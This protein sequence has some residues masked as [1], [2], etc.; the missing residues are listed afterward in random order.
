MFLTL[1]NTKVTALL[2]HW[3]SQRLAPE[4]LHWLQEKQALIAGGA[5]LR[6]FFTAFS[7]VPRYAGKQA[8]ALT[9][10]EL[11][12]AAALRP[13]WDPSHWR[14]DQVG[15]TFL[16]LALPAEPF[17]A[18]QRSLD[19]LFTAA[20]AGELVALYQAL[21]LLPHPE[22]HRARAAEGVRTN[23]TSVFDAV[24]LRNPYPAEYFDNTAWNQLVLKALFVD[25][26]LYLIQGLDQRA[27]SALARM[28]V[29]Y[30]HERWA[31]K[32]PVSPELWRPMGPFADAAMVA[33]LE[34]VL[35]D[36]DPAQ[37]RA[38]A[39]VCAQSDSPQVQALLERHPNLRSAVQAHEL[40]WDYFSDRLSRHLT[41]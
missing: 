14:L 27:N 34:K 39:L 32:R 21:P 10:Q 4:S 9:A 24:A 31:A 11:E 12:A 22:Q 16:V 23:M 30:A 41:P 5:P 15:R 35:A 25:R 20:D 3:L 1:L 33:D 18:Y 37:Q 36:P 7:A 38:A 29:D 19:Q 2:H 26:P 13:G 17:Q 40:T 6:V 8:L 28:L